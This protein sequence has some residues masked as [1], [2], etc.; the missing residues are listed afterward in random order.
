MATAGTDVAMNAQKTVS[1]KKCYYRRVDGP[2]R[3]RKELRCLSIGER[4]F[5]TRLP[6]SDLLEGKTGP[7]V[8]LECGVGSRSN[9]GKWSIVKGMGR[10][11]RRG[12]K[13]SLVRKK[14]KKWPENTLIEVYVSKISLAE[15]RL[16][17]TLNKEEAL[18]ERK[19]P[20]SSLKVG[21]ELAGTVKDVKPY[22]VFVDV[23]AN[24]KGLIHI[25]K[26]AKHAN[27]YI[28]KEEGFEKVGLGRGSS[29]NVVV[30]S[31]GRKRLELDLAPPVIKESPGDTAVDSEDLASTS[32]H[33]DAAAGEDEEAMWA[34]YASS[35]DDYGGD[36]YDEDTDI[37]DALGIGSY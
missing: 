9:S 1:E 16:E 14:I 27:S 22:G 4:L 19:I 6:E 15:G 32:A 37:E 25:S 34:A 31:N 3:P 23:N 11:G 28:A 26:V 24:R 36:D 33:G 21:E 35:N 13:K 8:F 29:V 30:V 17:V 10:V 20:A 2:W 18:A 7:K 5:A 12:M